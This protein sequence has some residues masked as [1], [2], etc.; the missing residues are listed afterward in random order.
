MAGKL[1]EITGYENPW[2]KY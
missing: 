1:G 2:L